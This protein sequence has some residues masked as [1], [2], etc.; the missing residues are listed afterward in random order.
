VRSYTTHMKPIIDKAFSFEQA[1][2]AFSYMASDAHF[3][4]SGHCDALKSKRRLTR[5]AFFVHS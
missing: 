3:W 5:A 4:E 1:Q 2:Q